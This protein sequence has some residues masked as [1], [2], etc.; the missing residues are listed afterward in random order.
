MPDCPTCR[1]R[2]GRY[3][4][5]APQR[6]PPGAQAPLS[7]RPGVGYVCHLCA[8]GETLADRMGLSDHAARI[9]VWN[10][11]EEELRRP[12][13]GRPAPATYM[14]WKALAERYG[15]RSQRGSCSQEEAT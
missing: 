9:A 5:L 11:F 4:T 13:P 8:A 15:Y 7:R 3:A 1:T 12:G 14:D 10:E 6:L 2:T